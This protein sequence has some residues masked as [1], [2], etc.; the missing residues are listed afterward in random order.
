[1]SVDEVKEGG[2]RKH[3]LA[4]SRQSYKSRM[5]A[6]MWWHVPD[7]YCFSPRLSISSVAKAGEGLDARSAEKIIKSYPSRCCA[8]WC[9][10]GNSGG[11]GTTKISTH[12]HSQPLEEGHSEAVGPLPLEVF[13]T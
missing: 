4:S 3:S 1:M 11:L 5:V 13:P 12:E 2:K 10:G 9:R 7:G 8:L 6:L